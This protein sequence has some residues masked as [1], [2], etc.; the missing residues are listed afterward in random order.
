MLSSILASELNSRASTEALVDVT[1]FESVLNQKLLLPK[2][3]RAGCIEMQK[4]V[5]DDRGPRAMRKVELHK[6]IKV[7]TG[8][9]DLSF[10]GQAV[11]RTALCTVHSSA[12]VV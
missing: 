3:V 10:L 1:R 8:H 7:R 9:S 11:S 2:G 6:T 4:A 5:G 12:E